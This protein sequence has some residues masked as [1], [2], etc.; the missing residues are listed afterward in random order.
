MRE[1][2]FF[3]SS[4]TVREFTEPQSTVASAH[5]PRVRAVTS[6]TIPIGGD[7]GIHTAKVDDGLHAGHLSGA[8]RPNTYIGSGVFFC[9]FFPLSFSIALAE[10]LTAF[11]N[12][13]S[14][15]QLAKR[16][17]SVLNDFSGER[18]NAGARCYRREDRA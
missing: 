5:Q 18:S 2:S 17:R 15:P 10:S 4:D 16:W 12:L 7:G 3:F 6:G 9:F 11:L 8:H 13:S 1:K 14:A